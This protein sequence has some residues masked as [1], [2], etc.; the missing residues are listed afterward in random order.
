MAEQRK[1]GIE[2][3]A[4]VAAS[5]AV[6]AGKSK[7][8]SAGDSMSTDAAAATLREREGATEEGGEATDS[9]DRSTRRDDDAFSLPTFD[10]GSTGVGAREKELE[11]EREG[12]CVSSVASA[13]CCSRGV[14]VSEEERVRD[15]LRES[16]DALSFALGGVCVRGL[17]R[18]QKEGSMRKGGKA[19]HRR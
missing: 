8:R 12:K 13:T 17:E 3:D 7:S 10:I 2:E 5:E 9:H 15:G 19:N 4:A 6:E 11:R 1:D 14:C 16:D 18:P